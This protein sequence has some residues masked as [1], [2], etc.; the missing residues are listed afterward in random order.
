MKVTIVLCFIV[1]TD[2][3]LDAAT[4]TLLLLN[5][6]LHYFCPSELHA[7]ACSKSFVVEILHNIVYRRFLAAD[8]FWE[9][10]RWV[11]AATPESLFVNKTASVLM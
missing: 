3:C 7:S 2:L 5:I 10:E 1:L 8:T 11:D 4:T 9:G 6:P